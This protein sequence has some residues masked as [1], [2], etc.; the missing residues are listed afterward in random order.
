MSRAPVFG[1][2]AIAFFAL[3]GCDKSNASPTTSPSASA[4]STKPKPRA[5]PLRSGKVTP[6]AELQKITLPIPKG[7]A[8]DA[9]WNVVYPGMV[10][11]DGFLQANLISKVDGKDFYWY[12]I[13]MSDCRGGQKGP[14]YEPCDEPPTETLDGWPIKRDKQMGD[15]FYTL[16]V[17]NYLVTGSVGGQ[18]NKKV[19]SEQMEAFLRSLDL[20]A[21][22]K[23]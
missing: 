4:A 15:P 7:V 18:A 9:A 1:S 12:G 23:L 22:S 13:V 19:S 10:S 14:G 21:I 17:G 8:S 2:I 6:L 3:A 16:V 11:N 5:K 20:D